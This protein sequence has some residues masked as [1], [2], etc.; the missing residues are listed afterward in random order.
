MVGL[1]KRCSPH[2]VQVG[3]AQALKPSCC[4]GRASASAEA[5]MCIIHTLGSPA[6]GRLAFRSGSYVP[7]VALPPSTVPDHSIH[8]TLNG[9]ST[10]PCRGTGTMAIELSTRA[11]GWRSVSSLAA[12]DGASIEP[13][14]LGH[15]LHECNWCN[16]EWGL[17]AV[18]EEA[19]VHEEQYDGTTFPCLNRRWRG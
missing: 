17:A 11:P 3:P 16:N 1:R 12:V 19:K 7:S 5:L 6:S 8:K 13:E 2:V 4:S 15:N 9:T 14:A 18:A 10:G